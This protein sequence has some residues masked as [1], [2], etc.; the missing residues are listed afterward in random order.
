MKTSNEDKTA[1]Y[2]LRDLCYDEY[3]DLL[4]GKNT[5]KYITHL[6]L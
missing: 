5:I 1:H 4:Q 6:S 2:S 3:L